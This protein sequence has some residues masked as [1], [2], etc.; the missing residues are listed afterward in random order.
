MSGKGNKGTSQAWSVKTDQHLTDFERN[1]RP[2]G[3]YALAAVLWLVGLAIELCAVL[4]AAGGLRID[5]FEVPVWLVIVIA[6]VLDIVI[7]FAG[8]RL[9][10]KAS[11][12]TA[13][14]KGSAAPTSGVIRAAASSAAF[15]PMVLFFLFS[16]NA[17][18]KTKVA[19]VIAALVAIGIA[20]VLVMALVA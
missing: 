5:G 10:K 20:V 4:Y 15:V 19:S 1:K 6:I 2:T 8:V 14:L 16:K 11:D 9:W 7:T 18:S 12:T 17:D 3:T 13:R